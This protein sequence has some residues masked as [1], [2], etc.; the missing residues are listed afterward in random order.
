M[1][2]LCKGILYAWIIGAELAA[3]PRV[4]IRMTP[5]V[6]FAGKNAWVVCTVPRAPQNRGVTAHMEFRSMFDQL[7]GDRAAITHRFLFERIPCT[8]DE[9]QCVLEAQGER[10]QVAKVSFTLAGCDGE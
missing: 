3:D 1:R 8:A 5:Q 7:D 10:P 9:A 2:T 4:S 6:L